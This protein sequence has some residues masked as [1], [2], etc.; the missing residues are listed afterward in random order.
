[1]QGVQEQLQ[2]CLEIARKMLQGLIRNGAVAYCIQLDSEM[3]TEVLSDE[4][5]CLCSME[6]DDTAVVP[7]V[8]QALVHEYEHLFVTPIELPPAQEAGHQ[9]NLIPGAQP[10]RVRPY[11]YSSIQNGEIE[12][13]LKE[14][15]QNGVVRHSTSAFASSVLL[16]RKKDGSWRFC[17]DYR[18]LNNMTLK[19]K[20]LMPV[21]EELLDKLS[22]AKVFTKLDFC[23]GYH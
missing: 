23:A 6:S 17:I 21:V 2:E 11:H 10:I 4:L 7:S 3:P 15:L 13:Q 9:I 16:V 22:G 5:Q 19:H 12:A 1:M 18:Q 8:V 14:M 20:H